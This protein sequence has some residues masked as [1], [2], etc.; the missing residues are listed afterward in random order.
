MA[1]KQGTK[2]YYEMKKEWVKV[3]GTV[4]E[5]YISQNDFSNVKNGEEVEAIFVLTKTN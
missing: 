2:E 5:P 3:L 4:L 1:L